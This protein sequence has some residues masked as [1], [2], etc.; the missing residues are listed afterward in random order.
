MYTSFTDW[1]SGLYLEHHGIKGQKWGIRRY[2][3]PDGTLTEAGKAR[4]AKRANSYLNPGYKAIKSGK[5][6]ARSKV[7]A[8]YAKEYWEAEKRGMPTDEPSKIG[9]KL[10][11][12]YKDAYADAT[13]KDLGLQVT[14]KARNDVKAILKNIDPDYDYD[15]PVNQTDEQ[16]AAYY[17]RRKQMSHPKKTK[18]KKAAKQ[19]LDTAVKVKQLIG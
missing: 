11:D 1:E 5:A 8:E 10:W 19:V 15:G 17:G 9:K 18:A 2:Q 4:L 12:K 6:P 13:L 7:S 16:R 3:N 14:A